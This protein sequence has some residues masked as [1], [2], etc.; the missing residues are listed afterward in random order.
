MAKLQLT[1]H[2]VECIK[3]NSKDTPT[4]QNIVLS[5][6][7]D[8]DFIF[9]ANEAGKQ[10]YELAMV[11]LY[12]R[13]KMY[14]PTEITVHL[15]I[16]IGGD[17]SV[18][19]HIDKKILSNL[20]LN[21]KATLDSLATFNNKEQDL[22]VG[23]DYV[24][25]EVHP[26]YRKDSMDVLMKINSLDKLL[27]IEKYCRAYVAKKLGDQILH[28]ETLMHQVPYNT[29][30]TLKYDTS[31]MQI[32]KYQR[33]KGTF[34]EH[35]HPYLV[36]YNESFYDMLARTTNRW[37]EFLFYE[38]GTL[39]VGYDSKQEPKELDDWTS[40]DICDLTEPLTQ[41][42]GDKLGS[43]DFEG[44]YDS[45]VV[46]TALQ[47]S[48]DK[49]R[50]LSFCDYDNGQDIWE[51]KKI[52]SL[53]G[54]TNNL[55]S[56]A[57]GLVI[58]E[59]WSTAVALQ[60][61][62]T[63]N[64]DFDEKYF[65][66]YFDKLQ[67]PKVEEQYGKADFEGKEKEAFQQFTEL[68][69]P[70]THELYEKIL[71]REQ[72]AGQNAIV[73][74]YDVLYPNL[75]LGEIVKVYDNEYLVVEIDCWSEPGKDNSAR[76][77]KYKV[78]ALAKN[79]DD[80][81][82][83]PTMLPS[84]H[85]RSSAPQLATVWDA[86]DPQNQ[87]RVRIHF[88]WQKIKEGTD[89]GDPVALGCA[90]PWLVYATSAASKSNGIF[91]RH[92]K[93]DAVL[94][95]FAGG[96]VEA[97]YVVGGLALKGNKVPGSLAERDIVLS[98]PGG[99]T[100][101]MD[102]GSGAGLT[103]FLAG[104]AVSG[105]Y[106]LMTTFLPSTSG[107]DIFP[108]YLNFNKKVTKRFEGGFQLTDAFG[109]YTISGSTDG[110][111][112]KVASPWGEVNISAFTGI[113]LKAPNG[114]IEIKGKNVTI[115]AGNNLELKSG[116]NVKSAIYKKG[117]NGKQTFSLNMTEIGVM[118]AKKL[119]QKVNLVDLAFVRSCV[120]VF[121]RPIEGALTLSSSRFLKLEAGLDD[122]G[123]NNECDYPQ[124]AYRVPDDV[125][126]ATLAKMG[127]EFLTMEKGVKELISKTSL[128]ADEINLRF[129]KLFNRCYDLKRGEGGLTKAIAHAQPLSDDAN[130]VCSMYS[131][132]KA[133]LWQK[134]YTP[135][136]ED[137]LGFKP[138]FRVDDPNNV[139][140]RFYSSYQLTHVLNPKPR[141]EINSG[142]IRKR[143]KE[144]EAI[145]KAADALH[146]ALTELQK[147]DALTLKK[148]DIRKVVGHFWT[149]KVP[150]NYF[151]ALSEAFS[152]NKLG[153]DCFYYQDFTDEQKKLNHKYQIL[154]LNDKKKVLRR[155][156][157]INLIEGLGFKEADRVEIEVVV[158][159]NNV[160]QKP[161]RPFAADDAV[162]DTKWNQYVR[163]ISFKPEFDFKAS[164]VAD[165]IKE[166]AKSIID[167]E[168]QMREMVQ[169]MRE[170]KAWSEAKKGE[171]LFTADGSTYRL[172]QAPVEVES[173]LPEEPDPA[174]PNTQKFKSDI[175][176]ALNRN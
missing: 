152:K 82:F 90:S 108:E 65:D 123:K 166:G 149:T 120:E 107:V 12:F 76:V 50:N 5:T 54:Y 23:D 88:P 52:A 155:K 3:D 159:G 19:K 77:W 138:E 104:T 140:D 141:E 39:S 34:N 101:R 71:N 31:N 32:L 20:F 14:Q 96:N 73:M 133:R 45:N 60:N 75:K 61:Q 95:N 163:S 47:K 145:V 87:N 129:V 125:K 79:T 158:N 126:N 162:N 15:H 98:S 84:G 13:K 153:N 46:N 18:W 67:Q 4:A 168:K 1:L 175:C 117:G 9:I 156:A 114:D 85:I 64:D 146:K 59:L 121:V 55:P 66:Q 25:M 72:Y 27:T 135:I 124:E 127:A 35:I 41:Q 29:N 173:F 131:D 2:D 148:D 6:Q 57:A 7:T 78:I 112:V 115:E 53:F 110:R 40:F 174:D 16:T 147:V 103:A 62:K 157:L 172:K 83:Y 94:V 74:N 63:V 150:D 97:P 89:E 128:L 33:P 26:S 51:M 113:S 37:G 17:N 134:N 165:A 10:K 91:G 44:V 119:A 92:Y 42:K 30:Q 167:N 11:D 49:L 93:G 136:T 122:D 171:I 154:E 116:G 142:I 100:L 24:V 38:N 21:K 143:R 161:A 8:K 36:Q 139:G 48:P 130:Q 144:R 80:N 105:C 169:T 176:E 102:D 58:D 69:S 118:V 132:L 160:M 111:E 56:F 170:N 106:D 137:D 28:D 68:N 86:N 22:K 43:Y 109:V 151:K 99:H 70:Y 164:K 81:M